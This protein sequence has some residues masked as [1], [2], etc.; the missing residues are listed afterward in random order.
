M[1]TPETGLDI[2]QSY[3]GPAN[4]IT[5]GEYLRLQCLLLVTHNGNI[6]GIDA[7]V[8]LTSSDCDPGHS[9]Q[10]IPAVE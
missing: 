9:T 6:I 2:Q 10:G 1:D 4:G 3:E 5:P 8:N 7:D